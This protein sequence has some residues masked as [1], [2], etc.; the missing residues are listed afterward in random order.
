MASAQ[1]LLTAL[2]AKR[3]KAYYDEFNALMTQV[4]ADYA[5][6]GDRFIATSSSSV[7]VGAG[8][9][10]FTLSANGKSFAVGSYVMAFKT[11]DPAVYMVGQVTSFSD[12]TLAISVASPDYSGSGSVSAWTIVLSAKPADLGSASVTATGGSDARTLADWTAD[13]DRGVVNL[14]PNSQW[15]VSTVYNPC[16][17]PTED[18][19]STVSAISVSSY[20]TGSNSVTVTC[21]STTPLANGMIGRFS[22]AADANMRYVTQTD[23]VTQNLFCVQVANV[24]STTFTTTLPLGRSPSASAACTFQPMTVGDLAGVS[25]N[26]PDGWAK[27]VSLLCWRDVWSA[28]QRYG[29]KYQIGLKK[30]S[31]SSQYFSRAT[32]ATELHKYR[33]RT[34]AFGVAVKQGVRGGSGTWR[35]GINDGTG[36][37]SSAAAS[38]SSGYQWLYVTKTIDANATQ[39]IVWIELQGASG[40]VYYVAKPV[41]AFATYL[42]EESYVA[43]LSERFQPFQKMTP[44]SWT[45]IDWTAPASADAESFYSTAVNIYPETNGCITP[46]VVAFEA[47]LEGVGQTTATA[48]AIR[49]KVG[50]TTFGVQPVYCQI[51][52]VFATGSGLVPMNAGQFLVYS[53][54][55]SAVFRY[56]SIDIN[57]YI[58]S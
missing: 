1:S 45:A 2:Q 49:N 46:E 53:N 21:G 26:G 42:T 22:S 15:Y 43:P 27:D 9:K 52:G 50:N 23:G 30:S 38:T 36:T 32:P 24:T 13:I 55:A 35:L 19:T 4:I 18:G 28:N 44:T 12:P 33:G 6:V 20:T 29:S 17:L 11:S 3:G 47:Q 25:G 58:L 48:M 31:G 39:V 10:T 54:A 41:I 34:V 56:A 5:G 40:D 51:E 37:T 16:D 8:S 14:C 57:G 7:S